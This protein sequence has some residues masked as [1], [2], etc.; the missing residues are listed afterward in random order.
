[1]AYDALDR[2]SY[3]RIIVAYGVGPRT[4]RIIQTYWG[5]LTM[6]SSSSGY[7]G[8]PFKGY[9]GI[10]QGNT[11]SPMIFNITVDAVI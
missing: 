6:L 3:L 2:Y 1:M 9:R 8:I 4:I 11:L 5:R 7:F 10:T